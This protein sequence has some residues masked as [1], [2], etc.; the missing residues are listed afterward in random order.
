MSNMT[1]DQWRLIKF[2]SAQSFLIDSPNR[3]GNKRVTILTKCYFESR[4]QKPRL[5][6]KAF[7]GWTY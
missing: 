6:D 7:V 5:V 2:C 4:K 3:N 1:R